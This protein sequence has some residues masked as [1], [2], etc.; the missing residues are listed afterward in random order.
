MNNEILKKVFNDIGVDISDIQIFQ[1]QRYY[2]ML[3][4]VNKNMNL[5]AITDEKD[6]IIKHFLDSISIVAFKELD[7][8]NKVNKMD[9]TSVIDIGTGAGFPGI[10]LK[11]M[12]PSLNITLVDSLNKRVNFLNSVIQ[13][14][15]LEKIVAIHARAEEIAKDDKYREKY[16]LCVS[17]AVANLATLSEYCLPFVRVNKYFVPYK[18][19][20]IDEELSYGKKCISVMGGKIIDKYKFILPET[21]NE[22]SFVYIKKIKNTPKKYPRS[23]NKPSK[24]P[25]C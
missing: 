23:G 6:V 1:F 16:D 3:I 2:E 5:T 17:R 7:F 19:Q 21:D 13:E 11:I 10:P 12:F 9:I 25:I 8:I 20:K 18:S 15:K 4:D 14:F 22:R 24:E